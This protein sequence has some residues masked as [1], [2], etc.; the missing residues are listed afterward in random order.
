M[1]CEV[2]TRQIEMAVEQYK[3]NAHFEAL[4]EREQEIIAFHDC[5]DPLDPESLEEET[6]DMQL[7]C[8]TGLSGLSHSFDSQH[9]APSHSC[10]FV[11]QIRYKRFR[12]V[13]LCQFCFQIDVEMQMP[14][15]CFQGIVSFVIK[16]SMVNVNVNVT[17]SMFKSKSKLAG[18]N[19]L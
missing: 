12:H 15:C 6:M 13:C 11:L 14:E 16:L 5:I 1:L 10:S 2:S 8:A 7:G 18:L 19:D 9:H 4:P 3:G 17:M